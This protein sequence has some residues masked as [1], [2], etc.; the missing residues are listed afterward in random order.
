V[1]LRVGVERLTTHAAD[2]LAE[3]K[4]VDIAV[5]EAFA[6]GRV[7]RFQAGAADRFVVAVELHRELE[8]GPQA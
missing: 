2:D 8:V 3:Q 1:P 5:D 6:R 7:E 4:E